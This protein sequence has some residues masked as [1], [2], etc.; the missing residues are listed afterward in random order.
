MKLFYVTFL[1]EECLTLRLGVMADDDDQA[2]EKAK[3]GLKERIGD[4]L[5]VCHTE[6]EEVKL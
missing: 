2:E 4:E 3:A 1:V 6:T 5:S